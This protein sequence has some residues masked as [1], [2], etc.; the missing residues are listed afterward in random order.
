MKYLQETFDKKFVCER[1]DKHTGEIYYAHNGKI[2]EDIIEILLKEMFPDLEWTP[3]HITNDGNKDF[4]AAKCNEIYW[5]ECKNYSPNIELKIVAPTL[6]MA[7]LCNAS[8]IFFFSVSPINSNTKKKICYYSQ[9]N[10]KKIHFVCDTVLEN[11]LLQFNTTRAF[12]SHINNLPRIIDTH[13]VP[14]QYILVMKNPFLN[15]ITDDQIIGEPIEKIGLNEIISEQIFIINNDI[16]NNLEFT[17]EV[18]VHNEDL[19]CFEYLE[20]C[21]PSDIAE[22]SDK[23]SIKPYEVFTKT[24]NFRVLKYKSQ[25]QLPSLR[26]KYANRINEEESIF[27]QYVKCESIGKINLVG[28][29]YEN[30]KKAFSARLSN[31]KRLTLFVC[32]GKSGVGKTRIIEEFAMILTKNHYKILNFMGIE[33]EN[34][35]NIIKEIIFVLY[36][37][38]D[39]ILN[40]MFFEYK[41][42]KTPQQLPLNISS[43]MK[44]LITLYKNKNNVKEFLSEY[45]DIIYEK[46]SYNKYALI[47]DN[48]Q[49]Y[50]DGMLTFINGLLVYSKNTNRQNSIVLCVTINEDYLY[51]NMPALKLLHLINKLENSAFIEAYP[52]TITGFSQASALLFLKQL[53]KIKE[54]TYDDYFLKLIEKANYNP[55]NIKHYADCMSANDIVSSLVNNQR[56]VHNQIAFVRM[57]DEI[58]SGLEDSLNERWLQL[59]TFR[60]SSVSCMKSIEFFFMFIL[61]CLH[62]FRYLSYE[63]LCYLGC[64]K[65][66]INLLEDFHFIKQTGHSNIPYYSFDHDLVEE[67]FEKKDPYRLLMAVK[68]IKKKNLADFEIDYPYAIHYISL[69]KFVDIDTL[70]SDIEYG[71][72]NE[73]PFRLFLNYQEHS[74]KNLIKHWENFDNYKECFFYA[75]KICM[76][77]RERLGG[78]CAHNFY[79]KMKNLLDKYPVHTYTNVFEFSKML[80]DICENFH[81]IG[82]YREVIKIYKKYLAQYEADYKINMDKNILNIIAFIYNR[83]SIAYNH[84]SDQKSRKLRD[85]FINRALCTSYTLS[86]RQ[87]Y[88]ESLYDKAEFYY[89]HIENKTIFISL[90]EQSCREVDDYKIELMYLHNLQRKIRLRFVRGERSKIGELIEEGLLYIDNGEYTEYRFFFSKFFHTSKALLYLLEGE[91]YHEALQEIILSI[92][93]TLSFGSENIAYN[94]FLQ[95]KI[96]FHLKEYPKSMDLYKKAYID[97]KNSMLSE[98]EFMLELVFDDIKLRVRH[99]KHSDFRFLNKNDYASICQILSMPEQDYKVYQKNYRAKSIVCSDDGKENYP[100][101]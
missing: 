11:L 100:C 9:I 16:M 83:M 60:Q 5:A 80:F 64:K 98:K 33:Q 3:T 6:V 35:F 12:F 51:N 63:E 31:A 32:K 66:Y 82:K 101:I 52:I 89:N 13:L 37:I 65:T 57:I 26:I 25:L 17:I 84:F 73:L 92:Q 99:F 23:Y 97:I 1:L 40:D 10:Q 7:Q 70:K 91:K 19:Y 49:Y 68:H 67:F 62:I 38:T 88:A 72:N 2:F 61:S 24:Y 18:D 21:L 55:Y 14:E 48:L 34:S 39:D 22:I 69:N 8:E 87:Y 90:C 86:N 75:R 93:D 50:D 96:Y 30:I 94:E 54:E 77:V 76:T 41:D 81:H 53:L 85:D 44:L 95:A 36:N 79:I 43:S 15:I 4:W 47:I 71:I 74:I 46:I 42:S 29:E 27:E 58:P 45:G 20:E 56:I 59:C 28:I 78:G